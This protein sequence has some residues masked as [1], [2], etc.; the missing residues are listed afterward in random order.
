MCIG[1]GLLAHI[2]FQGVFRI[3][4]FAFDLASGRPGKAG[5]ETNARDA[6][7]VETALDSLTELL[8][9]NMSDSQLSGKPLRCPSHLHV[10]R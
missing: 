9:I 8:P 6:A 7:T 4:C 5:W 10:T 2:R 1:M 3:L